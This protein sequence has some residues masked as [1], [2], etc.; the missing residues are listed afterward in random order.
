MRIISIFLRTCLK[1][2]CALK[3]YLE[4][5][6]IDSSAERLRMV[7][8]MTDITGMITTCTQAQYKTVSEYSKTTL[9]PGD[10]II[11]KGNNAL[12]CGIQYGILH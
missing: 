7:H 12:Q 6:P 8:T 1:I 11:E 9:K 3:K 2:L 4:M 10:N 5:C